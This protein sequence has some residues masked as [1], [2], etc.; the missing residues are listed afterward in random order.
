MP[1]V[2]MVYNPV[3]ETGDCPYQRP[4]REAMQARYLSGLYDARRVG[5]AAAQAGGPGGHG[6]RRAWI[7]LTDGGNGLENFLRTN[8]PR[9]PVVILDFW[10]A[11]D[12]LAD[13]AR[14]CIPTTRSASQA[15]MTGW[16]HTTKHEG[17]PAVVGVLERLDL[18]PRKTA[19]QE[20][21][22]EVVGYLRNNVHRMDYPTLCGQRLADRLGGGGV[23]VQDGGRAAPEAGG[24]AMAGVRH[25]LHVPPP[26]P[27]PQ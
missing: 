7:G 20:K 19:V 18:P 5:A 16:C 4:R 12:H 9:D 1:Y 21:R 8:F 22:A 13:L 25:G 23:G 15:L 11:A 26:R 14:P 6:R 3:P 27:V 24:D 2:G 10:H 17:G